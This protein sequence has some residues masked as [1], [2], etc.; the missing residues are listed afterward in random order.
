MARRL[1]APGPNTWCVVLAAFALALPCTIRA[2]TFTVDDVVDAVDIAPG[3]GV[4]ATATGGCSLRAAIQETNALPGPDFV[5][6]SD[7]TYVLDTGPTDEDTAAADDLD[8][9][10]DL[11]MEGRGV[12]RIPLITSRNEDVNPPKTRIFDVFPPAHVELR[13]LLIVGSTVLYGPAPGGAIRNAGDLFLNDCVVNGNSLDSGGGIA[14]SGTLLV[15]ST[16]SGGASRGGAVYSDGTLVVEYSHITEGGADEGGGIYAAGPTRIS[17]TRFTSNEGRQNCGAL[18]CRADT[19]VVNSLI[20]NNSAGLSGA[21]GCGDCRLFNVTVRDNVAFG[22]DGIGG[23][24]GH[25]TLANSLFV[26]NTRRLPRGGSVAA[27]C[28]TATSLGYDAIVDPDC[29]VDGDLSGLIQGPAAAVPF[30]PVD[31]G[32]PAGCR[33]D[34]GEVLT[35]DI[36]AFHFGHERPWPVGG[37]CDIGAFEMQCGDSFLEDPETCDDGNAVGGDCCSATCQREPDGSACDDGDACTV[38][39]VCGT[40]ACIPGGALDCGPCGACSDAGAC[41]GTPATGCHEPTERFS[42]ALDVTAGSTPKLAWKW[43]NGEGT[44]IEDFG[45][46]LGG[47]AYAMCIFDESGAAP[48]VAFAAVTR[49]GQCGDRPCWQATGARGFAYKDGQHA[50]DWIDEVVLRSG[51]DGNARITVTGNGPALE[52]PPLPLS[53]PARVQLQAQNGQCWEARFFELGAAHD[54]AKRFKGKAFRPSTV[55]ARRPGKRH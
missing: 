46:P 39:D 11:V 23:I 24:D 20:E 32:D 7:G 10:D 17:V 8:V 14:N 3:D 51:G 5:I 27:D 1:F 35:T 19:V 34:A 47:D 38:G 9:R 29:A 22:N 12:R 37:R 44:S 15:S 13:R 49:V 43:T 33:D 31:A 53:L 50:G 26:R 40:G 21:A 52:G 28:R 18:A 30:A 2:A 42:G 25:P 54:D 48:S 16:V 6:V 36:L 4:C 45:D 41:V 55:A